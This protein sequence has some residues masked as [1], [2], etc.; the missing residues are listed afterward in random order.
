MNELNDLY[1]HRDDL[2]ELQEA[3]G[4]TF[5]EVE[6]LERALTHRSFANE[7][8]AIEHNNQRLEFLG[9][10]VL[11]MVIAEAMFEKFPGAEEGGLSSWLAALVNERA[12]CGV[13]EGLALGSYVRLGKGEM[14]SGGRQKASVLAD[15]YEAV[16]AAVYLDSG[17]DAVRGVILSLHR[18][19]IEAFKPSAPPEDHKSRLQRLVQSEGPFRPEYAIIAERGPAHARIFVAE[20]SVDGE[21]LGTGEGRSKKKAQQQAAYAALERLEGRD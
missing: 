20:V 5:A 21:A 3:L 18:E 13:A 7:V 8:E 1:D 12:L 4:H 2:T 16:L 15:A 11:G 10:A 6:L 19:A 9:D 17:L 14:L